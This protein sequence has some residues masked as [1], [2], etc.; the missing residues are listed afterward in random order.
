MSRLPRP[1]I[2]SSI[3]AAVAERQADAKGFRPAPNLP[4]NARLRSCLNFLFGTALV[5]LDHDPALAAREKIIRHGE[6][7][8]YKPDANDPD[9]LVYRVK[10]GHRVKTFIRGEHGQYPDRV[11]IKRA[12]RHERK[13]KKLQRRWPS[14]SFPKG[15]K[16]RSNIK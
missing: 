1:Y 6:V 4:A 16:L 2:P 8:G 7:V 15:R 10:E 14:R 3:R 11:L 12:R 5:H 9:W 13:K